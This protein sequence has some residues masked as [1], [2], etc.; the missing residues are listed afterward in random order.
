M[1]WKWV[2]YNATNASNE[3]SGY[4]AE[5]PENP[6][7]YL[8]K[9]GSELRVVPGFEV[10][11]RW[12][13]GGINSLEYRIAEYLYR[14]DVVATWIESSEGG[15]AL[16]EGVHPSRF[17]HYLEARLS[18]ILFAVRKYA[19][20]PYGTSWGPK[21]IVLSSELPISDIGDLEVVI[22]SDP[23]V[24]KDLKHIIARDAYQG[25]SGNVTLNEGVKRGV[26]FDEYF[27]DDEEGDEEDES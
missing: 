9:D 25:L 20:V 5:V 16:M 23:Y 15:Q 10:T 17:S 4:I 24:I 21:G 1:S 14:G 12:V 2:P 7:I 6:E 11:T 3:Y 26:E 19:P 27:D 22:S 8:Y 13:S 18:H